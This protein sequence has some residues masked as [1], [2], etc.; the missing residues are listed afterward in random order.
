MA[1]W[2]QV[3]GS[4]RGHDAGETGDA[5]DIALFGAAIANQRQRFGLHDDAAGGDGYAS[6]LG[7][8]ADADHHGAALFIK[9]SEIIH[10]VGGGG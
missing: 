4:L 10:G 1:K 3:G 7:F 6:G 8:L 9:M 5:K 2:N